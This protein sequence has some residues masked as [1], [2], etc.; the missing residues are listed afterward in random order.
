[1]TEVLRTVRGLWS[2]LSLFFNTLYLWTVVFS[3]VVSY[4][5]FLVLFAPTS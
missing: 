4:H 5:D 1:M 3:L 2:R